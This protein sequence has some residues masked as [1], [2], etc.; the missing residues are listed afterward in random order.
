MENSNAKLEKCDRVRNMLVSLNQE[1]EAKEKIFDYP[2]RNET[3]YWE[4][5]IQEATWE[6]MSL[7]SSRRVMQK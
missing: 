6:E 7:E 1:S 5:P 4:E 3:L 2:D